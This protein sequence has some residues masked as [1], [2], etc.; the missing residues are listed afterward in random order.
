MAL[1]AFVY[2]NIASLPPEV[3]ERVRVIDSSTGDLDWTDDRDLPALKRCDIRIGNIAQV[4]LLREEVARRIGN[5][6]VLVTRFLYDGTHCGD[7]VAK[8]DIPELKRECEALAGD[9]GA[10]PDLLVFVR[11]LRELTSA[12]E[13]EGNAILF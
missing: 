12:A 9:K 7:G 6:S 10:P 13:E 1:N 2:R 3:R 5:A 4:A 8:E 11:Q